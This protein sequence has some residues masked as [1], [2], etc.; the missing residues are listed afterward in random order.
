MF[1][2]QCQSCHTINGFNGIKPMV[3][4]WRKDF[5]DYQL[6]HL[7]EL[8]GFMPPFMGNDEERAALVEFL[9]NLN[10]PKEETLV[11]RHP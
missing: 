2:F 7:D 10:R 5:L 1:R 3:K 6:Q 8:K 4:G 11:F 9:Y